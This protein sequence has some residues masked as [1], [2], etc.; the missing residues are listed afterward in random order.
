MTCKIAMTMKNSF[1]VSLFIGS[2]LVQSWATTENEDD[3]AYYERL[4]GGSGAREEQ[5]N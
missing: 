1:Q 5:Q 4:P 2:K 3:R